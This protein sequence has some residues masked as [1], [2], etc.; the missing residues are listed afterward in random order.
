MHI[1]RGRGCKTGADFIA[2]H[3]KTLLYSHAKNLRIAMFYCTYSAQFCQC[4]IM[5]CTHSSAFLFVRT[6]LYSIQQAGILWRDGMRILD[7]FSWLPAK[8][9]SIEEI[10]KI[11]MD[12]MKGIPNG[13][14]SVSYGIPND[15]NANVSNCVKELLAE[16]KNVACLKKENVIIAVIGYKEG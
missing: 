13:T 7:L 4:G 5:S 6:M 15:A 8:E 12:D 1:T 11:F 2:R 10:E 3:R 9:I 14:Y 16:E